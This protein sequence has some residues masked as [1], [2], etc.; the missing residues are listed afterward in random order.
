MASK[1]DRGLQYQSGA[2]NLKMAIRISLAMV[3]SVACN[4][5][6]CRKCYRCRPSCSGKSTHNRN[7]DYAMCFIWKGAFLYSRTPAISKALCKMD[8][9][10]FDRHTQGT[11]LVFL[12][13]SSAT[14]CCRRKQIPATH[15]NGVELWFHHFTPTRKRTTMEWLHKT[16]PTR[17]NPISNR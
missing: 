16:S 7:F 8:A 9:S 14:I 2:G 1:K 5:H 12:F 3:S 15:I 4:L 17:K 13:Q 6:Q 10:T 11:T